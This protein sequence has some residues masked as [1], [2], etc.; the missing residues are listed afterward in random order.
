MS[1]KIIISTIVIFLGCAAAAGAAYFDGRTVWL[2]DVD[3]VPQV[4][5][6][7]W[8]NSRNS[9]QAAAL[10]VINYKKGNWY[11]RHAS[12]EI[13]YQIGWSNDWLADRYG[14]YV[15]WGG[16]KYYFR[17]D[18]GAPVNLWQLRALI[19]GHWKY[20]VHATYVADETDIYDALVSGDP[21][22]VRV[23]E[24]MNPSEDFQWMVVMGMRP[25]S[26][27]SG[28]ASVWVNDPGDPHGRHQWYHLDRFRA[29]WQSAG[30]WAVFVD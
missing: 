25:E 18:N 19:E 4:P 9:A 17:D 13:P 30:K 20:P 24:D 6:G 14:E 21:V 12:W 7:D 11:T 26:S 8:A 22:I 15:T 28:P 1:K 3:Y 23:R 27:A 16:A 10:T 29:A 2:W 5:D